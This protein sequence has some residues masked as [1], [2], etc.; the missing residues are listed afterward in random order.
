MKINKKPQNVAHMPPELLLHIDIPI[1]VLRSMYLLPSLMYRLES[2]MLS[3][4]LRKEI[5]NI[6]LVPIHQVNFDPVIF[7]WYS[8]QKKILIFHLFHL[9]LDSPS[10]NHSEMF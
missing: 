6:S 2:L 3:S 9:L 10:N 4:Q 7:C 8:K 5:N 1:G